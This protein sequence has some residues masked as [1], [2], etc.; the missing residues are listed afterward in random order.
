MQSVY[1]FVVVVVVVVV[2]FLLEMKQE[3]FMLEL[4]ALSGFVHHCICS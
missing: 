1:F 2:L 4:A 3:L